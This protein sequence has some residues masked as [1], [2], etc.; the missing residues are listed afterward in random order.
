MSKGI[1]LVPAWPNGAFLQID[2]TSLGLLTSRVKP[3]RERLAHLKGDWSMTRVPR[4]FPA[5]LGGPGAVGL[6][7]LRLVAGTAMMLHGWP[8]RS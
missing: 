3:D 8:P 2:T 4:L 5:F 1:R 6:L 7:V